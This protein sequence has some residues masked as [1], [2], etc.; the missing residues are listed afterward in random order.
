M[1][2]YKRTAREGK[3]M[4]ADYFDENTLAEHKSRNADVTI[5]DMPEFDLINADF[6]LFL[7]SLRT[8]NATSKLA[9]SKKKPRH[10]A[11]QIKDAKDYTKNGSKI[12]YLTPSTL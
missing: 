1:I 3:L 8:G 12:P 7:W 10:K 11:Q 2:M 9:Y 6:P 5:V 4:V